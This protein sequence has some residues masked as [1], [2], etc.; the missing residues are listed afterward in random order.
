[1]GDFNFLFYAIDS[2]EMY[3]TEVLVGVMLR[4]FYLKMAEIY[5]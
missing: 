4:D 3:R 2:F 1:M 5:G